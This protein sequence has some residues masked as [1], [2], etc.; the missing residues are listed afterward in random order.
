MLTVA[1]GDVLQHLDLQL[2]RE[3][4][5]SIRG[6]MAPDI[7]AGLIRRFDEPA[8]AYASRPAGNGRFEIRGA[9]RGRSLW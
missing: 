5:Y 2:H 7:T 3:S 1:P 4:V 9:C 8:F 6:R